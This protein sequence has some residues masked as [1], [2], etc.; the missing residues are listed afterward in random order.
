[1]TVLGRVSRQRQEV[2]HLLDHPTALPVSSYLRD[3]Q[4]SVFCVDYSLT[5][6]SFSFD[7]V[8]SVF[9]RNTSSDHSFGNSE[10]SVGIGSSEIYQYGLPIKLPLRILYGSILIYFVYF[11][12]AASVIVL[13]ECIWQMQ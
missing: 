2:L 3:A 4:F 9:L 8:L 11:G 10:L 6:C 5:F 12:I 1:M 7:T 13:S